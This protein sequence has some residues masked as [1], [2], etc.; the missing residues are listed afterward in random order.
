MNIL[1]VFTDQQHREALSCMGD[2]YE[3]KNRVD[4]VTV[5]E[6]RH[7]MLARLEAWDQDV[8]AGRP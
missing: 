1:L 2:P 6:R 8:R 4:D 3:L 5:A 7:A